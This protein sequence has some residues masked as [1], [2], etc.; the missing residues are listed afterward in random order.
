M[1]EQAVDRSEL[2]ITSVDG[3]RHELRGW[4]ARCLERQLLGAAKGV[5]RN[6]PLVEYG[7]DSVAAL[8]LF[9]EIEEAFAL[10]LE[11]GEL[12]EHATLEALAHYLAGR[13]A[14]RDRA[15]LAEAAR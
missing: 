8:G 13:A 5:G 7:L 12:F 4:L 11:L 15:A 14:D 10:R 2:V 9:G 3:E 1:E 6:V